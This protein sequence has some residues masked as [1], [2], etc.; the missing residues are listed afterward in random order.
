M[1]QLLIILCSLSGLAATCQTPDICAYS[2][3]YID[4]INAAHAQEIQQREDMLAA[5]ALRIDEL[6]N[7]PQID[8]SDSVDFGEWT[9]IRITFEND[10]LYS[11]FPE[12]YLNFTNTLAEPPLVQIYTT[13]SSEVGFTY[14]PEAVSLRVEK[15][16]SLLLF[17]RQ[18]FY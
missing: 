12:D 14:T 15:N 3:S 8:L 11:F 6:E 5:Y 1:K 4:S 9:M 17:I 10:T 18:F 2:Q 13:D 16:D 7:A